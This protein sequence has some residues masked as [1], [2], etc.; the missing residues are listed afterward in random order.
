MNPEEENLINVN[1]EPPPGE[2]KDWKELTA[3]DPN[4]FDLTYAKPMSAYREEVD[5]RFDKEEEAQIQR[6]KRADFLASRMNSQMKDY[7]PDVT[8]FSG[9]EEFDL[10]K[11]WKSGGSIEPKLT[12]EEDVEDKVQL[13]DL[14]ID[15]DKTN[16]YYNQRS[17]NTFV[18]KYYNA[19]ELNS[20]G[21]NVSDFQGWLSKNGFVDEFRKDVE[22]GVFKAGSGV[23][24]SADARATGQ[25]NL[26]VA[27]ERVLDTRLSQYMNSVNKK[28]DAK[29][30]HQDYTENPEKY[31][32]FKSFKDAYESYEIENGQST[33][34][35]YE[36][37]DSYREKQ[38]ANLSWR[39]KQII[40]DQ[41]EFSKEREDQSDARGFFEGASEFV[42]ETGVGFLDAADET[43]T[44][45]QD[46]IG[47]FG[48]DEVAKQK[49]Y[50]KMEQ[51]ALDPQKNLQY[52]RVSGK[53]LKYNGKTYLKDSEGR[54]YD[55][56]NNLA[57]GQTMSEKEKSKISN[58]IDINGV[59]DSDYSTRGFT[60]VAGNVMGN[61]AF[62]V[63]GTKGIGAARL[64]TSAR[65][66]SGVNKLRAARGLAPMTTR[67]TSKIG[68]VSTKGTFGKKLPFDARTVDASVFQTMYGAQTGYES[69]ITAAK[70]AGLSD[71]VAEKLANRAQLEMGVL[72]GLTGPINPRI[73]MLNKLDD[74]LVNSKAIN[75][76]IS[77]FSSTGSQKAFSKSLSGS[78]SKLLPNTA[79]TKAFFS[80]GLKE[81][82]QENI[83]QAG[84]VFLVN[85]DIN[86]EAGFELLEANYSVDDFISTSILSM[87]TAGLMAGFSTPGF[88]QSPQSRLT[89]LYELSKNPKKTKKLLDF[90]VNK[91]K[92]TQDDAVKIL[93]QAEA[94]GKY[95]APKWMLNHS[96]EYIDVAL[97]QQKI[98][99]LE[100]QKK[101]IKNNET[102]SKNVDNQ[103]QKLK[104]EQNDILQP[105]IEGQ[106]KKDV[107]TVAS[108]TA[109]IEGVEGETIVLETDEDFKK[110]NI[111]PTQS[112]NAFFTAKDG[113][114]YINLKKAAREADISAP[115]HELLHKIVSS[116]FK[117]KD[118][119]LDPKMDK[120]I[121]EFKQVLKDKGVFEI[122]NKRLQGYRNEKTRLEGLAKKGALTDEELKTATSGL[123][124]D[125]IDSDE[126]LTQFF[127][128]TAEGN[129]NFSDLNESTWLNLGK[130][131]LNF[132]KSK[133]NISP[134]KLEFTSGK[135]VFDFIVDYEKGISEGKLT[136][137][138]KAGLR[139]FEKTTAE[140]KSLSLL[141]NINNLVP[142]NVS[143][144]EEFQSREVFNPIFNATQPGGA[145]YNYVNSRALSK[146][147][148]E[149]TLEGVVD[150]LINFDPAAVRKTASGDPITFGE[151][152]FA[153]ARFSKL[154]AKK[155]LAIESERQAE[156]LDTEEARQV[157]EPAAETTTTEAPRVEYKNLVES[158]VLPTEMVAKVQDKILLIT[159]TLKSRID[160][161][162]SINKTVTPLMSEIKKEIG[163]QADIEF[164]KMLGAK[165]GG[166]LRNNF[167]KLKKPI[168]ENMTT[169][170]L[171]QGMP[172]AIQKSVDGKFTS[173]WEGKKIDR[174][175]VGTDKAG[176]T[177]GA[178]LVRRLPNAANKITDEQ[179]LTYMF[180]GD[181][182]IRGR[183]E[184]LAKALAEEYAF[185]VY[186]EE[187]KNPNS[188]IVEAFKDNQ[189]RLGAQLFDNYIQEFSKQAERGSV[190]RSMSLNA[191]E[192]SVLVDSKNVGPIMKEIRALE[193]GLKFTE[194][195]AKKIIINGYKDKGIEE[196]KLKEI[197]KE[198]AASLKKYVDSRETIGTQL[199]LTRFIKNH[200]DQKEIKASGEKNI[201]NITG[202]AETFDEVFDGKFVN[203]S[204]DRGVQ[205]ANRAT[206][207]EYTH[208]LIDEG[209]ESGFINAFKFMKGHTATAYV[210][211]GKRAQYFSGLK[212]LID[213]VFNTHSNIEI[214]YTIPEGGKLKITS[215]K[216]NGKAIESFNE[217]VKQ[218]SQTV[219]GTKAEFIEDFDYRKKEADA[220][221]DFMIDYLTFIK[222]KNDPLLW[223]STMKSLDSN[224]KTML[225]AAANVEYYFVGDYK[226]ELV[227]EHMVP[228]NHMMIE[229]TN[230]F[231][232]KKVNLDALKESYTVGI[233]P[234][235]MDKNI[236]V[237]FKSTMP[238][239][240]ILGQ[241]H[242]TYR[243]YNKGTLGGK[244]IFALEKLGGE[245]VGEIFGEG[246]VKFNSNLQAG[247]IAKANKNKI[248]QKALNNAR[249]RS[250]SENPK[251]ISVYDFDDTLA[252][253]KSQIIVKKDGK[254]FKINAAQFAKQGETLLAEGA[255]FDFSEF[256]K[257]V[258]GQPGPLIPRIQKAI[259]KFG[260]NN[261]FI[262]TARPVA[263]ESAIHAFM[264]GLGIDIPRVNITGLANS[265][266]QAKADWMVGKVAEGFNDFYFVDD[267]IKNVQAVKDVLE[268]FDVKS[269]VQ[270][271][272]ANRKRSMSSDLN[273]MIERNKGVR[274]E[275]TYSKVLARKKGAQKGK[276]RLFVPYSAE[277]FKGLTSYTLA[278]K[279]KQGEADQRL[280][281]QNLILPYTRGI[282]AME[283]A[284][285]ALKNDY[286]NL[287]SMFGLKKQLPKKIG[288][289]D[290][291][292]DQAIRVYLW[293]QQ[294]F[295]IPNI[296]KRDQNKLSKLVAKDPD[297][298][299]FAEGLMAVSKKDNWV[300]PKEHWD[301]G[302]I[303]KDLND[304]TDNVNRK[305]YLAEFIEN[306]DE[307]FNQT[308]LNK[309][310]AIYGTNYVDALQDSIRRMKSGSNSPRSAGKIEQKWLNWVNNS[311]GTI[312][313]FNRRSAL[314]QMLSFTNF[315]NW[316]DNNPA[317]AAAA[318]ANQPLY[319]KNWVKIFNS[320]KLK[321]RRG[322][323]KSDIQESEIANQAKNSKDKAAA[324]V[325][326]L[327]KI[328]FT[329]TQIA[330][331]FA[332]ATGGSTFLI[333]RT[334]KYEKQGLSKKE[335]EAKAFEDFGRISDET[336][337]SGDP[338]LISQQ[339]SSHLGRLILAF[340]N[341]PMQYVRLMKKAG[342]DIVN[343]RGSDVENLSKIAYYGFVQNLIFSSLQSAL[344][345]LIPGFDDEE[346]DDA[347]LEDKAIRT[348]NSMVDTILRGTG[349]A[350]AVIATLKNAIMRYKKED[351][352]GFTADQ[353]Y[354]MLELANLSPPIGSKLRKVYS[355]IQTRK[356]NK[357]VIDYMGMHVKLDG[358]LNP[359]PNY[360]II[361]NISSAVANIPADR[362]L[363][364]I[365]SI[366]EAFD[367][368]NTSY[369]RAALALGW[370]T[371]DVNV[372]NEEQDLIKTYFKQ[373]RKELG[374][375]KAAEKRKAKKQEEINKLKAMTPEERIEYKAKQYKKKSESARKASETRRKNKLGS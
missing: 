18:R 261:I 299:G 45:L 319:W 2:T 351:E 260:N 91:G 181:E 194:A 145:I 49:R 109:K 101:P 255:E 364:E 284:T 13:L 28:L 60:N 53:S 56:D 359:S 272:V 136:E 22:G 191:A 363:S 11:T 309:L 125:G 50:A 295:D 196:S 225:K 150:R 152:L 242:Q 135:Q 65:Y 29:A 142:K 238:I 3:F 307:M 151:F 39:T 76:A 165:R 372:K 31:K 361:A 273:E 332:I 90:A 253:S 205:E 365:K 147:E 98:D 218:P 245:N 369:Q 278:G 130:K 41:L 328:G 282:A 131:I 302:S 173:D 128:L 119:K 120:V 144:K 283:G 175:S 292:T 106:I 204:D 134:K 185:D 224:M 180:K 59:E 247:A 325:S 249:K 212:D 337:Q 252:F 298:V 19:S 176:R 100:S 84:E 274:A 113:N 69:T 312:M 285:Q 192:R 159:K 114:I 241:L 281:D 207:Q 217:K 366:N 214:T 222:S 10:Y 219:K 66:I 210:I 170:W 177:S 303:L 206:T 232:N 246:W 315:I 148:A 333:N 166:E 83:Q 367:S 154:D 313:F 321:E 33:L 265:T 123:D 300:N 85:E 52:L 64:A 127:K 293:D 276:F 182:V 334:K 87:S 294:G 244:N 95:A 24:I 51:E 184:A 169:T 268:N 358:K 308:N 349:I 203:I 290:F 374:K 330:D 186:N 67:A 229:L 107:E 301:V 111:D 256:N 93:E 223:V 234:K 35:D 270:Q 168:L 200:I 277:D 27:K 14:D 167:L 233:V 8:M 259:D 354:T 88:K 335:A 213:N 306:V 20:L 89:N 340:Q 80:E 36:K 275:T 9:Q 352:K 235:I 92:I 297:L 162:T 133:L 195:S 110:Y 99:K 75:E 108:E 23:G 124:V 202:F 336:Q 138:A 373:Q 211:G 42:K 216:Y 370:R 17:D 73:P 78:V 15:P 263:S 81:T 156:S 310:E 346:E 187:F 371:W 7:K 289:T 250:Y 26:D 38:F 121:N 1:N 356:F 227:Y 230:H 324:V 257:V 239:N 129:I 215:V 251:G 96:Q 63:L 348:A 139:Q 287:L 279:G 149:I 368:R 70:Q 316:S 6:F 327:L 236:N 16:L 344:F 116:Q 342:K 21:V 266:A 254:T 126:W 291:T 174:E 375:K 243:Y 103:I 68:F 357:D 320:D 61:I 339:Q 155:R 221:F 338:M 74:W 258:K 5:E 345:A 105:I 160:A 97:I 311:V 179:F 132:V 280:F 362:L 118:G 79:K 286:K 94:V 55:T 326:Y 32:E 264:K 350:G 122:V 43:A 172:F 163:K 137:E 54:L 71:E 343:R 199:D 44:W 30:F 237:Q 322:G 82:V 34:F 143:T 209:G 193:M 271:A 158:K 25:D 240:Y 141:E 153:N 58:L 4:A 37:L 341:T 305:E 164:K 220:A 226:G 190:K 12:L 262:L 317:K 102:F 157:A 269:K 46:K 112:D 296:S 228:T 318:F 161:A 146:E 140:K 323:L 201:A 347:K 72:Y 47:V 288:G 231:W 57:V 197:A 329:P 304:I 267:A 353:T 117:S 183:K 48:F 189:S 355:A 360:E 104:D 314:L 171:M 188:E 198:Y 62:Q 40:K 178:Q 77:N 331:S 248:Q 115:S 208:K 86:R